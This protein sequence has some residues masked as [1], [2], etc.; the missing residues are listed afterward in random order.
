MCKKQT[1]MPPKK[2][3]PKAAKK[4]DAVPKAPV[5]RPRKNL[6]T[7]VSDLPLVSTIKP[8][9]RR[10]NI[11]SLAMNRARLAYKRDYGKTLDERTSRALIDAM[12]TTKRGP[13]GTAVVGTFKGKEV[14]LGKKIGD[15]TEA[16]GFFNYYKQALNA[17]KK[18]PGQTV[19]VKKKKDGSLKFEIPGIPEATTGTLSATSVPAP[20]A[21]SVA[22]VTELRSAADQLLAKNVKLTELINS[23]T[24][25]A[26]A[27]VDA[28]KKL[29]ANTADLN[30]IAM[31]INTSVSPMD[32][33]D[34]LIQ[35]RSRERLRYHDGNLPQA[36]RDAAA[37]RVRQITRQLTNFDRAQPTRTIN[38]DEADIMAAVLGEPEDE[39]ILL[40]RPTRTIRR[41][42]P[43]PS[44]P[45]T[46]TATAALTAAL[47]DPAVS[48]IVEQV[49]E[50][51]PAIVEQVQENAPVKRAPP[52]RDKANIQKKVKADYIKKGRE[53]AAA[54]LARVREDRKALENAPGRTREQI[55]ADEAAD[56]LDQDVRQREAIAQSSRDVGARIL[57]QS[58]EERGRQMRRIVAPTIQSFVRVYQTRKRLKKEADAQNYNEL[59]KNMRAKRDQDIDLQNLANLAEQGDQSASIPSQERLARRLIEKDKLRQEIRQAMIDRAF[60]EEAYERARVI[61][62]ERQEQELR[63]QERSYLDEEFEAEDVDEE[64]Y[65]ELV[66]R[67][68]ATK[69][70]QDSYRAARSRI[71]LKQDASSVLQAAIRSAL[72]RNELKARAERAY[73]PA[74]GPVYDE[75]A[76]QERD[77]ASKIQSVF[78]RS[79][80]RPA[81][82][83]AALD[84]QYANLFDQQYDDSIPTRD[85]AAEINR[86]AASKIQALFRRS[87]R[88]PAGEQ[89]ALDA[90]YAA[91]FDDDIV[92]P[93]ADIRP[94]TRT[95]PVPPPPPPPTRRPTPL[96]ED[97]TGPID[98][99]EDGPLGAK[100]TPTS[101]FERK[102]LSEKGHAEAAKRLRPF[103]GQQ[104]RISDFS[105]GD[106]SQQALREQR[107][108]LK[109]VVKQED[110]APV[111]QNLIKDV[112]ADAL[113][114]RRLAVGPDAPVDDADEDWE[115]SP[116]PYSGRGLVGGRR[117]FA[118]GVLR[119]LRGMGYFDGYDSL[120]YNIHGKPDDNKKDLADAKAAYAARGG[121]MNDDRTDFRV[122]MDAMK[123][124]R[125][126]TGGAM[127]GS[128]VLSGV[129]T[130]MTGGYPIGVGADSD[131]YKLHFVAFPDDKWTTSSSLRWIRSNGIV[132]IKKAMHIPEYYKYQILPP[133]DN[134]DYMTHEL[135]SRG[136]KILLGYA[137]P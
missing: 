70:R 84:A 137:R 74:Q 97:I 116:Y 99:A 129:P 118:G 67:Q 62:R 6:G 55:A 136:R 71:K 73:R 78:R 43:G 88:R 92:V 130:P 26:D 126:P 115:T 20:S 11:D 87:R 5:G 72:A 113:F 24:L 111:V 105:P 18:N 104:T 21:E 1:F 56:R 2:K 103:E 42:D 98:E 77:A 31:G 131:D 53:A 16:S 101:G 109:R 45:A 66:R 25:S 68:A 44:R 8:T 85:V 63:D 90:Q 22:S 134:K 38:A 37:A 82:E 123:N 95:I 79:R 23:G 29:K 112:I 32:D 91:L 40:V 100:N 114:A 127:G 33:R 81:G 102:G 65:D 59:L 125:K 12:S 132:P 76:A 27:L 86:D 120:M 49:Q 64:D 47:A 94:N 3:A 4:K 39:E 14:E 61:E 35:E 54:L 110:V 107:G 124:V 48:A 46:A 51:A 9:S 75:Q 34:L 50:N 83:Q 58:T 17:A 69:L 36:E 10:V 133:S 19:V 108:L 117:S 93:G 106:L 89:A 128:I 52:V 57:A 30:S 13:I 15:M 119:R 60:E 122:L 7:R 41:D 121:R 80:R 135:V 96:L 28:R